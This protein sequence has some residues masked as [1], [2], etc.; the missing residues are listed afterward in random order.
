MA[1][2]PMV[3]AV[4][5]PLGSLAPGRCLGPLQGTTAGASPCFGNPS[6]MWG[7][8]EDALGSGMGTSVTRD[9]GDNALGSGPGPSG[10]QG[11]HLDEEA[12][13]QRGD[14]LAVA[15]NL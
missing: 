7:S 13:L 12:V 6:R 5:R 15:T 9:K 8:G 11:T 3:A 10:M 4:A 1:V 2:S 14:I